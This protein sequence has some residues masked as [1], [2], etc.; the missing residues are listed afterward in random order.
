MLVCASREPVRPATVAVPRKWRRVAGMEQVYACRPWLEMERQELLVSAVVVVEV[1]AAG[2]ADSVF[3]SELPL[4]ESLLE[5]SPFSP[6]FDATG[7]LL[8]PLL[9]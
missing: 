8:D 1:D 2:L 5:D 7:A 9:A 4:D 3:E 6:L